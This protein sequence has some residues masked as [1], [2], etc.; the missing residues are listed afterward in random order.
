[1]TVTNIIARNSIK[2]QG[3]N[4]NIVSPNTCTYKTIL[5]NAVAIST[6]VI[7]ERA[8][9]KARRAFDS[10]RLSLHIVLQIVRSARLIAAIPQSS[11]KPCLANSEWSNHPYGILPINA[12]KKYGSWLKIKTKYSAQVTER[13]INTV[14]GCK[15]RT[16]PAA[17]STDSCFMMS[18][19]FL[20]AAPE[21]SP[22]MNAATGRANTM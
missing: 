17:L 14:V 10:V 13:M 11:K 3:S 16:E 20:C 21:I 2:I 8:I 1:M 12:E 5:L 7:K 18:V 15:M 19:P 9:L 4:L 22:Y 6:S